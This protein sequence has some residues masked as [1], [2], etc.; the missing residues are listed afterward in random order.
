MRKSQ[1]STLRPPTRQIGGAPRKRIGQ[2]ALVASL[3][4]LLFGYDTGVANGAEGP[5]GQEMGLNLLQIGFVISSLV[6]AAALGALVG[7]R[8]SDTIGRRKTIIYL[9]VMFFLGA[10][11]VVFAPQP[12]LG[13]FYAPG[14]AF[15]ITGRIMLGLAV[16][17]ASTVVPAYLAEMAPYEIRGTITGRNELAIVVGQLLAF[18]FNALIAVTLGGV[19]PGIWR[20]MFAMCALPAI[21]LFI[22][23][24]RMPESPR[25]LVAQGRDSEALEVLRSIRTSDQASDELENIQSA[26]FEAKKSE[27][28]LG[29]KEIF[30]NKWL[31]RILV[32]GAVVAM[33]QRLTGIDSI[34]YYGTRVLQES[35]M[36]ADQA[37]LANISYGVVAVIGGI[38]A[39]RNMDRLN[40]RTTFI[41]GLSLTTTFHILI[42]IAS[43]L[44]PDGNPVRPTVILILTVGFVLSMQGFLNIAVWVWLAEIF[45]LQIRGTA[46]GI[47]AAFGWV[48]NGL[49]SLF[50]PSLVSGV[51]MT[52]TFLIFAGIGALALIF[53]IYTVPETRGR[54][55]E[56][57]ET[58]VLTGTIF[59]SLHKTKL[60]TH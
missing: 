52:V 8:V 7:G 4:G 19:I 26:L 43:N 12:E 9:A 47:A 17:G 35:G 55:L 24:L 58:G 59:P 54:T 46:F 50:F 1:T 18:V 29:L 23:M 34:M 28:H 21:A 44:L 37:V 25:W 42:S 15:L 33:A 14:F 40:R 10:V 32:V 6:F 49:V 53:I 30:G 41:I 27:N 22:G 16:G 57:V 45:P 20:V 48:A 51:G 31:V 36:S 60:S 39:L 5:M 11:L 2:I 3:G 13:E 56:E 38:F